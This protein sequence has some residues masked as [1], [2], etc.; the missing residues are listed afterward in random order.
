MNEDSSIVHSIKWSGFGEIG[1]KLVSPVVTI[2]LAR[3]LSPEAFGVIAI[4]NMLV[5]FVDIIVD[6]GF[7][8]YLIQANFK[9]NAEYKENADVAFWTQTIISIIIWLLIL[10]C[11]DNIAIILGN[12]EYSNVIVIASIQLILVSLISTHTALLRRD[13]E[14]KKLFKVRISTAI[15][16]LFVSVPFAIALKSY[17][18]LI[19]GNLAS[20]LVNVI[21]LFLVSTWRP[22]AFFSFKVLKNMWSFSF[23]SMC[24][25]LAHWTIFWIDI[26]II[27]RIYSAYYVGLYKNSTHIVYSL[28]GM[29]TAAMSPVLLSSLSRI[30][31]IEQSNNLLYIIEKAFMYILLPLGIIAF[32]Y[33]EFFTLIILGRKWMES[34]EILGL[35]SIMMVISIF[36]Y[37]FPAEAFKSRG[38]PKILFLYQISYLCFII[39]ICWYF[40]NINFWSFVY[41]RVGCIIFQIILFIIFS[42]IFLEWSIAKYVNKIMKPLSLALIIIV[43]CYVYHLHINDNTDIPIQI[44]SIIISILFYLLTAFILYKKDIITTFSEL[45]KIKN[46]SPL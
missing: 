44:I 19:I 27:G 21:I 6:A 12:P 26:F 42:K 30:R 31:N 40:A 35:W 10:L 22:S 8:K 20:A 46:N 23:W 24:E 18:A 11:K 7:S 28:I 9:S 13:F 41:A 33:P 39:P 3:I 36:I 1:V 16:P 2:I 34:S 45:K 5:S 43:F 4:C 32:F 38:I 25:G 17:W 29:V 37:S 15:I 14:F